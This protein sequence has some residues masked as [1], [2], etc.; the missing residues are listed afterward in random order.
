MEAWRN[1]GYVPDSDEDDEFESQGTRKE[2]YNKDEELLSVQSTELKPRPLYAEENN[3]ED[4][5]TGV[6]EAVQLSQSIE[7]R[8]TQ[9]GIEDVE[10]N[11][12]SS[13][14]ELQVTAAV[15]K[16]SISSYTPKPPI[17]QFTLSFEDD[18]SLSS[19][20]PPPSTIN[21]PEA[22]QQPCQI[23]EGQH[24]LSQQSVARDGEDLPE[25]D[26]A[27]QDLID[28]LPPIDIPAEVLRDLVQPARRSLRDRQP[29]QLHPY[30]L[31]DAKY[32]G[33][34]RNSGIKPVRIPTTEHVP[35]D[36]QK[37]SQG[38]VLDA[39]EPPPSSPPSE[40]TY[41]PSSPPDPYRSPRSDRRHRTP[42]KT[43]RSTVEQ[44]QP[45]AQKRRKLFHN[46]QDKADTQKRSTIQVIINQA[47]TPFSNDAIRPADI[48]PSPPRSG[49]LS[50]GTTTLRQDG[51][52]FPRGFTPPQKTTSSNTAHLLSADANDSSLHDRMEIDVSDEAVN[53]LPA[54]DEDT[55]DEGTRGTENLKVKRLQRRIKGVLPASWLRLDLKNQG[56]KTTDLSLERRQLDSHVTHAEPTKGVARKVFRARGATVQS[57]T[58]HR[59]HE[60][61]SDSSDLDNDT[62]VRKDVGEASVDFVGFD[63]HHN[64]MDDDIPED[65]RID[66]MFPRE[67]RSFFGPKKSRSSQPKMSK[68]NQGSNNRSLTR[69]LPRLQAQN[70]NGM[71]HPKNR[72]SR[73]RAPKLGILDAP[74]VAQRS[75]K[76]QS[77]FLRVAARQVRSRRDQGRSSP[78]KKFFRMTNP[79]DTEDTNELLWDWRKG[80]MKQTKLPVT[81]SSKYARQPL[82]NIQANT[83]AV[84]EHATH[85]QPSAREARSGRLEKSSSISENQTLVQSATFSPAQE[86][87]VPTLTKKPKARNMKVVSRKFAIHSLK[88]STTRPAEFENV[89]FEEPSSAAF[90]IP[91]AELNRAYRKRP[92]TLDRFL[93]ARKQPSERDHSQVPR[94]NSHQPKITSLAKPN[95]TRLK[96]SRKR[97][98]TRI[99]TIDLDAVPHIVSAEPP[100]SISVTSVDDTRSAAHGLQ[101]FR[102]Y[103][104]FSVD[105][106][107]VP[108]HVGTYFHSSTFIGEGG[109]SRSLNMKKRDLDQDAG[110]AIIDL[111]EQRFRWGAWTEEVSSELGLVIDAIMN[112]AVVTGSSEQSPFESDPFCLFSSV[113]RYI[114][115]KLHFIDPVDR[116]PFTERIEFLVCKMRDHISTLALTRETDWKRCLKLASLNTILAG[117]IQ[118][119]SSHELVNLSKQEATLNLVKDISR[120]LLPMVFSHHGLQNIHQFYEQNKN[121]EFREAGIRDGFPAVEAYIIA[122]QILHSSH[123]FKGWLEETTFS[124]SVDESSA[125]NIQHL[126]HIWKAIFTTL[127]LN[128]IDESGHTRPRLRSRAKQDNWP[129]IQSLVLKVLDAYCLNSEQPAYYINY[130]RVVFE[131]CFLLMAAWGW[132]DCK[133]ILQTLFGF[134]AKNMLYN[135]K[136]EESFGSPSFLETLDTN[137][138]IE[139]EEGDSSFHLFL[140]VLGRGLRY[141]SQDQD[142]KAMKNIAWRFLP[143]HGRIYPKEKSLDREDLNALRNHHDLLCTLYWAVPDGCRPR[144]EII[145]NLVD[146]AT[147]HLETCNLS[148]RSWRRLVH[149]KLS[150]NEEH[151]GLKPF[152]EWYGSFASEL[153]RQHLLA[154]TE[155][156]EQAKGQIQFSKQVVESTISHNQRQIEAILS[157]TVAAME[158]A[159][160]SARSLEQA[161]S[162]VEEVPFAKMLGLFDPTNP[163]VNPIINQTLQIIIDFLSKESPADVAA[164]P[165]ANDDSQEYGDWSAI[166]EV[167]DEISEPAKPSAAVQYL[168]DIIQPVV[169]ELLSNCFGQER[170]PEDSLLLKV[171]ECWSCMAQA[172]VKNGLHSWNSYLNSFS[173]HSWTALRTTPQTKKFAPQFLASCIEKDGHF[174]MDCRLQ[175]LEIWSSCL[176]ERTS[177]L[178]FQHRLTEVLLNGDEGLLLFKNLPFYRRE[179]HRYHITLPEFTDRRISLIS[180]LLSNMREHLE[181]LEDN[182]SN[183]RLFETRDEYRQLVIALMLSMKEN[184]Q[185]LGQSGKVAQ[186]QYVEFV[187]CIV[188]FMQQH[189]QAICPLDK[190]F[191]DPACFPPQQRDP[192]YIVARLKS[193]GVRLPSQKAAK[194]LVT[195][196]QSVCEVAALDDKQD[197]L[198]D[199]LSACMDDTYESGN[200]NKPTLRFFLFQC[201]FPAYI[202][203]SLNHAAAWILVIPIAKTVSRAAHK[204]LCDIDINDHDCIVSVNSIFCVILQSI[205]KGFRSVFD[206]PGYFQDPPALVILQSFIQMMSSMLPVL[207]YINRNDSYDSYNMSMLKTLGKYTA[208][209]TRTLVKSSTTMDLQADESPPSETL[210]EQHHMPSLFTETRAFAARELQTCLA[211]NWSKHEGKYF[212]R[213][214]KEGKEVRSDIVNSRA[215]IDIEEARVALVD[216]ANMFL[217]RL[218][219][220]GDFDESDLQI[221]PNSTETTTMYGLH[222][223]GIDD[224]IF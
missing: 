114:N 172:L 212:I 129:I 91:L 151:F 97:P 202:E 223:E 67:P 108:V 60:I 203:W 196:L 218:K 64:E 113:I 56:D 102:D 210:V 103:R 173:K 5:N 86:R 209:A 154:K 109:L 193:Y 158:S 148:V 45:H 168:H 72:V 35:A 20:S 112:D 16:N 104:I 61:S 132:R 128:A 37:E 75:R 156:E 201:V 188:G 78:N 152:A 42:S 26:S 76:E 174:F 184:Y 8:D 39:P 213:R 136:T 65:N 25:D 133:V 177:M 87:A 15:P 176:V 180:S 147:S 131:R 66:D 143:N 222:G 183:S 38:S 105:F 92:V 69:N 205:Q 88:R 175:I 30:L 74:D 162:L 68:T 43:P 157:S 197:D 49:S 1:T 208:L 146:P 125:M 111:G 57:P 163:R 50:S 134:Y 77:Q 33:Q 118:Q 14:D 93:S 215:S 145:R 27:P 211:T 28:S 165:A 155:V 55:H 149:F 2:E 58:P 130:C 199:Q 52:R 198:V 179:D 10:E 170:S 71:S 171:T 138:V 191:T 161:C 96:F 190:Y 46:G 120:Q 40:F 62:E 9:Q 195:F 194:A 63:D 110:L 98:P 12:S 217:N 95:Q 187:H 17:D 216:A 181:E 99:D 159:I 121:I 124:S 139:I 140:K 7:L 186:G 31:E 115:D 185:E 153:V 192:E 219:L 107:I 221:P 54:Q 189:S 36:H 150:T 34:F 70:R 19:L 117:Q 214:G 83:R 224:F 29:I 59:L 13:E 21:S 141:L 94:T 89:G 79:E 167:Y 119:I 18:D 127:P 200:V 6:V 11:V 142:K 24:F 53:E 116:T 47:N 85:P 164:L 178:K 44:G 123:H 32:R 137:P 122:F 126:E 220:C 90:S 81:R 166:E 135:L 48:P 82:R 144:V 4:A 169:A 41:P 106:G 80:A 182:G 22:T 160:Q 207:D 100:Q 73:P 101:G 204:L 3:A 206:H 84:G 23:H 51:F